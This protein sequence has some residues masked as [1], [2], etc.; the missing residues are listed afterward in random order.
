MDYANNLLK[1][2]FVCT[3]IVV[4]NIFGYL[5]VFAATPNSNEPIYIA[6]P[7]PL[8][9]PQQ[10]LGERML[11]AAELS[12]ELINKSGGLLNRE[13]KLRSFDDG[14]DESQA[15][16]VVSDV[17]VFNSNL[18]I[19]H[20][21]DIA[22]KIATEYSQRNMLFI[23]PG[24]SNK[25]FPVNYY[26][27]TFKFGVFEHYLVKAAI[28]AIEQNALGTRVGIVGDESALSATTADL[29][30]RGLS[31]RGRVLIYTQIVRD[32]ADDIGLDVT[33]NQIDVDVILFI[34]R[35]PRVVSELSRRGMRAPHLVLFGWPYASDQDW[36]DMWAETQWTFQK[37]LVVAPVPEAATWQASMSD[38]TREF[39]SHPYFQQGEPD[40]AQLY[41]QAAFELWM[42]AVRYARSVDPQ[43]IKDALRSQSRDTVF[44]AVQSG[45]SG[46]ISEIRIGTYQAWTEWQ[47]GGA[48]TVARGGSAAPPPPPPP[49][50][51]PGIFKK[52]NGGGPEPAPPPSFLPSDSEKPAVPAPDHPKAKTVYNFEVKPKLSDKPLVLKPDE[53]TFVRF[54]I[55]LPSP[56]SVTPEIEP[57]SVLGDIAAGQPVEL[58]VTM[59]CLICL[60]DTHQQNTIIYDPKTGTSGEVTFHVMPKVE[61]VKNTHGL[62]GLI[63]VIDAD[64]IDIDVVQ[65]NVIVGDP[66]TEALANYKPPAKRLFDVPGVSDVPKPDLVIDIAAGGG[67]KLPVS[68]RA[69]HKG[70]RQH[71]ANRLNTS[72]QQMWHFRSGV[73]KADLDDIVFD[74]YKV[75]RTLVEQKNAALQQEAE[76][77]GREITLSPTA[78]GLR[79]SDDDY[80][81]MLQNLRSE[82]AR[83]YERIF[84]RGEKDLRK[85]MAAID[86]FQLADDRPLRVR[87][88]TAD[89]YAPWQVLYPLKQG[90]IDP[91]RFWGFRY[92]LGVLNKSD[93]AQARMRFVMPRPRGDDVVFAMWQGRDGKDTV[94]QTAALLLAHLSKQF[95]QT[96][97]S[98]KSR[99]EL[100][101]KLK[102]DS[103]DIKLIFAY[104]HGTS[105][106][107]APP[108]HGAPPYFIKDM[109]G[110]RFLFRDNDYLVPRH[111]DDIIPDDALD[112]E[113]NPVFLRSQPIVIFNAC[114]TGSGGVTPVNNNGFVAA[115]TRSGARSVFVTEAPVWNNFAYYFGK[116]LMDYLIN[117]EESQMALYH[118]R[119]KQLEEWKNPLGLLYSLYGNPAARMEK[120]KQAEGEINPL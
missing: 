28:D 30:S 48:I 89:V 53:P 39:L 24:V 57:A 85:T 33:V 22:P 50:I 100:I 37:R 38:F 9:G 103:R 3:T 26:S 65:I 58:T 84:K 76:R 18:V 92:A 21:S 12:V 55:G 32:P 34:G 72:S 36:V 27:T 1:S 42:R 59:D 52:K 97:V 54:F 70:L 13:L 91:N 112:F 81:V 56:E 110:T 105:G 63:F 68:I 62:G 77:Q 73:N 66:T 109:S 104:G 95:S 71:I 41:V 88:R 5:P 114:E 6:F 20:C 4:I 82:G 29:L 49:S 19:G 116:Q 17:F 40:L 99:D 86:E 98:V 118:T 69:I 67:G 51:A 96:P 15:Y 10:Q 101:E 25:N 117:G 106:T 23:A 2:L 111:L 46:E 43:I 93:A 87:I 120:S 74:A 83:L 79:F 61:A 7:A 35:N 80:N 119:H 102:A 14:C 60:T 44:G 115:L 75:F 94:S 90:E 78:A 64:G 45:E 108:P 16:S 113:L 31:Q 107:T 11:K 47:P 8:S